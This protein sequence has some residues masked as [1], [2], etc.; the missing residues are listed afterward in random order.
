MV[1]P[2]Q[3]SQSVGMLAALAE[4]HAEVRATFAEAADILGYDLWGLVQNG[5]GERLDETVVT[6]PA[7]LTA[8]VATWRA[9]RSAGG[10]SPA[11]MAGHSLGE[12]TALVCADAVPFENAVRLVFRRA[13]LMQAA[14]PAGEGAMAAILGLDDDAVIEACR[15]AAEGRVVSAVNFNAPGQVV[16][17]GERVAVERAAEL[18]RTAGAKRALLLNVSVPSHCDLMR[19]AAE[20]LAASLAEAPLTTPAIPVIGN[21]DVRPYEDAGQIRAGLAKQLYSPVRWTETVR[22]L[23]DGGSS[24]ILECGPGKVLTGLAKRI[25]RSIPAM[26]IDTRETMTT[27]LAE[28]AAPG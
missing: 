18:A 21:A 22:G 27:A 17:A 24:S 12:Y 14:V 20:E 1:F 7:M 9:W 6:Q 2:G 19:P 28:H 3:G 8:G 26:C 4:R 15:Q 25:D 23:I 10:D 5:P 16:I 11:A 13:E